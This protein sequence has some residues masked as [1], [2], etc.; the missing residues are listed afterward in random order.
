MTPQVLM[1]R[2][3]RNAERPVLV[4]R[5]GRKLYHAIAARDDSIGLVTL[6]SLR[7]ARPL[8]RRGEPYPPRKAASFWLNRDFRIVTKRARQVLRG[9]VARKEAA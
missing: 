6:E 1:L 7:G 8:E 2:D 9:L 4:F 3:E 5:K